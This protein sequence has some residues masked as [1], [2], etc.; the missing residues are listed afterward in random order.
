MIKWSC[1]NVS[2]ETGENSPRC[3]FRSGRINATA[4]LTECRKIPTSASSRAMNSLLISQQG[5]S[6]FSAFCLIRLYAF[7][8]RNYAA[9]IR[10]AHYPRL[11]GHGPNRSQKNVGV[12]L[13][14]LSLVDIRCLILT[15][16]SQDENPRTS[17]GKSHSLVGKKRRNLLRVAYSRRAI[18]KVSAFCA[19]FLLEEGSAV[20]VSLPCGTKVAVISSAPG[21]RC[22]VL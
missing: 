11:E 4:A 2:A 22:S 20:S 8:S 1:R 21:H 14:P 7:V 5:N 15:A 13:T 6:Y 12:T 10:V 3:A 19:L 16:K 18:R 17:L 9:E